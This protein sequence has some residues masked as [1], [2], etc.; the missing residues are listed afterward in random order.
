MKVYSLLFATTLILAHAGSVLAAT[1]DADKRLHSAVDGALA[2]A[3]KASTPAGLEQS[4][5]PVLKKYISFE[6]MT[7]RAVGP[8]WRQFSGG[9]RDEATNLF[10]TL[11]IRTYSAKLTPG[12]QPD[13]TYGSATEPA[14]GRVEVPTELNYRGGKYGVTYRL[15]KIGD[16][17]ITDVVIEGVS[18][19][20]NYRTQL[21]A[22]FKNGGAAAVISA[23][24]QSVAKP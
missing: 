17:M 15:E 21:D 8:G 24:N 10:T 23:L 4:L 16:W 12:E 19:I 3:A 7:R 13:I 11:I 14:A 5:R 1:A 18:L 22:Q 2:V 6:A 9:Q 20:A